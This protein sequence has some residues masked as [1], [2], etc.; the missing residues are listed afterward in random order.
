VL[1]ALRDETDGPAVLLIERAARM[2]R[3]A[4]Q[5]GFPGGAVDPGDADP[6]ATALREAHEEVGLDPSSVEIMATLPQLFVPPTRF[7][8]TPVLGWWVR[9][10]PVGVVDADEVASVA[11]VP[12]AELAEPA[13]RFRVQHPSGSLGPA[14]E[15]GGLFIWGFT[16]SVLDAVLRLGGWE[17]TWDTQRRRPLPQALG[18]STAALGTV[19]P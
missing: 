4:G 3:H 16:A 8:V 19:P 9:P 6:A 13:N 15:A 2:R 12:L 5:V 7:V 1:I 17:R 10:H 11:V 18:G 14:F